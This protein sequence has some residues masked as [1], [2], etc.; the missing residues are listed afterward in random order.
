MGG[1]GAQTYVHHHTMPDQRHIHNKL[2][3]KGANLILLAIIP[4]QGCMGRAYGG[5]STSGTY[6]NVRDV[7]DVSVKNGVFLYAFQQP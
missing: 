7:P 6:G 1:W 2:H 3:S 4:I 5:A